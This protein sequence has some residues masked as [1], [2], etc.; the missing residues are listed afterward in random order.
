MKF[1]EWFPPHIKPYRKGVYQQ[2]CGLGKD[3]GYQYWDGKNWHG[4][5]R[6]AF[7]AKQAAFVCGPSCDE[8]R[9]IEKDMT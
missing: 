4:W 7:W 1:T 5:E 8:W 3:I 9:G 6:T 2:I